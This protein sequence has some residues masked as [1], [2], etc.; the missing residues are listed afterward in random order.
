MSQLTFVLPL[1][2]PHWK[3]LEQTKLPYLD[4]F[5]SWTEPCWLQDA[6]PFFKASIMP[7]RT[8]LS[9]VATLT[10]ILLSRTMSF[11]YRV[12]VTLFRQVR[13]ILN[14]KVFGRNTSPIMSTGIRYRNATLS[15]RR[16][17]VDC[18]LAMTRWRV[19]NAMGHRHNYRTKN[20][21]KQ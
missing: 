7:S 17:Q 12:W 3:E 9:S 6:S 8:V 14:L 19:V 16:R 13:V 5:T 1:Y 11:R 2:I 18:T 20:K 15:S 4:C 10:L 21:T